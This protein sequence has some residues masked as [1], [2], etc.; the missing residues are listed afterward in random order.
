MSAWLAR[1][2]RAGKDS[3][4]AHEK[5]MY[6]IADIKRGD[7]GST[8]SAYA[9][10][11]LSGPK[12]R[13]SVQILRRRLRHPQRLYGSDS[14]K[15]FLEAAKGEDKCAF[16]LVKTSNPAPASCRT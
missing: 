12:S 11:W 13:G 1:Y 9:E 5:G 10:G 16:V 7:I 15:P 3:S 4:Y 2:G 6:V 8:A 14:I